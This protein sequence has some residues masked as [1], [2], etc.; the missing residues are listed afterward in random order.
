VVRCAHRLG[1]LHRDLKPANVLM[2]ADGPKVSDF[3]IARM[4]GLTPATEQPIGTPA[5]MAPESFIAGNAGPPSDL[6]A[7]GVMLHELLTGKAP[8]D[9]PHFPGLVYAITSGPPVTQIGAASAE[10]AILIA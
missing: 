7:V 10:V 9:A 8:F 5:F 4:P 1:I 3:G 2:A 6:W